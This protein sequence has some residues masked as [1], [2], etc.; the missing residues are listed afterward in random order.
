MPQFLNPK[1]QDSIPKLQ[2]AQPQPTSLVSVADLEGSAQTLQGVF[3]LMQP[4]AAGP[5]FSD[6]KRLL[7][8]MIGS[9]APAVNSRENY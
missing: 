9:M 6:V 4:V 7:V 2:Q 8:A 5:A 1:R 3:M